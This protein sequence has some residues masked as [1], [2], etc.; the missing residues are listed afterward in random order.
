[1][2]QA[3]EGGRIKPDLRNILSMV[4]EACIWFIFCISLD[5]TV[6]YFI[7][8]VIQFGEEYQVYVYW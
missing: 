1:M 4:F 5:A 2:L 8:E 6:G 3:E 7:R